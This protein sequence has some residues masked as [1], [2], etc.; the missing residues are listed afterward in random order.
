MALKYEVASL[1]EL[2]VGF[3]DLYS[4]VEDGSKYFLNV[5]GVKPLS[6]FAKVQGALEKERNDHRQAKQKLSSFG[7]LEPESIQAQLARIAELEELA[8]GS[9]IDDAKLES[10]VS[11][12]LNAKL[13]PVVSEKE[14]LAKKTAELE[15]QVNKYQSIERQRRMNDEFTAKIKAA[16][17]DPRF[18]ET[19]MLK[20]ERLFSETEEGKFLTKD[21][22][23]PFEMWLT[24][25]QATNPYW[26]GDSIGGGAKGSGTSGFRG[27][28]P[29]TTGNLTEQAKMIN[30]N[31]AL[32]RTLAKAAGSKIQF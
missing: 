20:A 22:Y 30:E 14:Q 29:F 32:A 17:I 21:D 4:A 15:E 8:K 26:W 3:H 11:A 5:E 1:D 9:A 23:L 13:Q 12:R 19:V 7:D 25:Q 28:N 31:I 27:E 10:M 18:E 6:E 2:D 24:Q 16:K